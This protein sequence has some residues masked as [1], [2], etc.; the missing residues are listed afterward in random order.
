MIFSCFKTYDVRGEVGVNLDC[1][2]CYKIARAFTEHLN[3]KFI[4]VGH[5]A[6]ETSPKFSRSIIDAVT[7]AG[8]DVLDLGLCGTEEMY[9]ATVDLNADGGVMITASHNPISYNGLKMVKSGA[10]PLSP[11]GDLACIKSRAENSIFNSI[12]K[13]GSVRK[14]TKEIRASYTSKLLTFVDPSVFKP[15]RIVVNSG[16]G[17]AGP[18]F[19]ALANLLQKTG[20]NLTFFRINHTPDPLFPNGVPNPLLPENQ[21][22]TS[23][24]VRSYRADLG[25]AFDGDFD[26]C[27]FFDES[28]NFI[29]GEYIVGL[30]SG[31]FL[32]KVPL[33]KIVYDTRIIWNIEDIIKSK[34]GIEVKSKVGHVFFKELMRK[35]EAIYGGEMSGHHFFRD[36]SNCDSGMIPWLMIVE[37][38]SKTD[39]SLSSL[40]ENRMSR[41]KSSGEI[42]FKVDSPEDTIKRV[43]STYERKA[44][45]KSRMDGISLS[46]KDWR[47]NLRAS[48]TEPLL[49]LNIECLDDKNGIKS[50]IDEI[51]QIIYA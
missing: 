44:K 21:D 35:Q 6:R 12:S 49:R 26:R 3:A 23:N 1:S 46:F 4:V 30:L 33:A 9:W 47:F 14:A 32:D 16:N 50:K 48:N 25:I 7:D 27:F 11:L 28:G 39:K 40:V 2:I 38:M 29:P 19:D 8:A 34:G 20:T 10:R 24:M 43:A 13:K 36:F 15:M 31:I 22:L 42:N 17:A 51:R 41:F 18:S 37:L 45:T 5:D